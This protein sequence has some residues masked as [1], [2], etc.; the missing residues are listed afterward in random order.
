MDGRTDVPPTPPY[1]RDASNVGAAANPSAGLTSS[2]GGAAPTPAVG[3][4][5]GLFMPPRSN[6]VGAPPAAKPR[7]A[8]SKR[9]PPKG[10]TAAAP[11]RPSKGKQSTAVPQAAPA[12]PPPPPPPPP[13]DAP[14]ADGH[15]AFSAPGADAGADATEVFD[16][17]PGYDFFPF[18]LFIVNK[19]VKMCS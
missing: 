19:C 12:P 17:S 11:K 6:P 7:K 10:R 18:L 3:I 9:P 5:R 16:G 14:A 15:T 8:L 2:A 1:S 4:A 13:F